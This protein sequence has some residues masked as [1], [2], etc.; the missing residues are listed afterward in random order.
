MTPKT[1]RKWRYELYKVH[2]PT[3][4]QTQNQHMPHLAND[5]Y[6]ILFRVYDVDYLLEDRASNFKKVIKNFPTHLTLTWRNI[7]CLYLDVTK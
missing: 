3:A 6:S 2:H 7:V 5:V 1:V 4:F